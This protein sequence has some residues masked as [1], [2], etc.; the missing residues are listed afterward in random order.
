M[1]AQQ[2]GTKAFMH[3]HRPPCWSSCLLIH[4]RAQR[5]GPSIGE[6]LDSHP[7]RAPRPA[8]PPGLGHSHSSELLSAGGASPLGNRALISQ[9]TCHT[10]RNTNA[11]LPRF[12]TAVFT[13]GQACKRRQSREGLRQSLRNERGDRTG[14]SSEVRRQPEVPLRTR[15]QPRWIFP[16]QQS[17]PPAT[18]RQQ[19]RWSWP[20]A[21]ARGLAVETAC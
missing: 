7:F 13:G 1:L 15:P 3:S 8:R 11:A 20:Y 2:R 9:A 5:Q 19:V 14:G 18:G 6:T 4:P 12:Q 10:S 16:P 17:S 21:Q